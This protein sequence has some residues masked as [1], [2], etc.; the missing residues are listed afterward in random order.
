MAHFAELILQ[1]FGSERQET[2]R[3][4][5]TLHLI[6]GNK[7][8]VL[9]RFGNKHLVKSTYFDHANTDASMILS[10][11]FPCRLSLLFCLSFLKQVDRFVAYSGNEGPENGVSSATSN[12]NMF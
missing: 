6:S 7:G 1:L 3:A 8:H 5:I 12:I 4:H 10:V 2:G 9:V 11:N